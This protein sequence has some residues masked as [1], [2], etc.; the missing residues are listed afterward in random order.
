MLEH[1]AHFR[2]PQV[3]AATWDM[4]TEALVFGKSKKLGPDPA[5]IGV[6]RQPDNETNTVLLPSGS[7]GSEIY[8]SRARTHRHTDT[9]TLRHTRARARIDV[10]AHTF[11]CT[12]P[13][14]Y[15]PTYPPTIIEG[16]NAPSAIARLRIP[17]TLTPEH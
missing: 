4:D 10:R 3:P 12:H 7:S 14:T 16:A 11:S 13:P 5:V 1:F 2:L 8:Y 9:Q 15:P 17:T 6:I